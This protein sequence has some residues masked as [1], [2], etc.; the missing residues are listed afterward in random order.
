M[1]LSLSQAGL[2]PR[3]FWAARPTPSPTLLQIFEPQDGHFTLPAAA[4]VPKNDT[5]AYDNGGYYVH[6]TTASVACFSAPVNLPTRAKMTELAIWYAR[7]VADSMDVGILPAEA[8]GWRAGADRQPKPAVN[9]RRAR[10]RHLSDHV[11]NGGQRALRLSHPGLHADQHRSSPRRPPASRTPI[12]P[13]ATTPRRA[14][15]TLAVKPPRFACSRTG[16]ASCS[17]LTQQI[18]LSVT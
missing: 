13:R 15:T 5:Q 14:T 3:C 2:R 8:V 1:P 16:S 18:L 9:R 17:T 10:P 11:A 12:R 6:P 7:G 4:F